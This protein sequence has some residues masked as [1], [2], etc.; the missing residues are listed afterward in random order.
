MFGARLPRLGNNFSDLPYWLDGANFVIRLHNGYQYRVF[1]QGSPNIT[2]INP[3]A[4][5]NGQIGNSKAF[6]LQG[7][8][9]GQYRGMLDLGRNDMATPFAVSFRSTANCQ[10]IG[11]RSPG[12][13]D[14]LCRGSADEFRDLTPGGL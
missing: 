1:T 2:D 14:C 8:T 13:E 11:F 12:Q 6:A 5:G 9:G 10:I 4:A 3:A 7:F